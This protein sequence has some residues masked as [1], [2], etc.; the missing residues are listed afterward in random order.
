[1][2]ESIPNKGKKLSKGHTSSVENGLSQRQIFYLSNNCALND[3]IF[4][5]TN[6]CWQ[7][8]VVGAIVSKVLQG[9]STNNFV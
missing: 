9:W 7:N 4:C 5:V 8:N 2:P 6:R 1:M 3:E